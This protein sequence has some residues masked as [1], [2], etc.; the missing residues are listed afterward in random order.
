MLL[1]AV[2]LNEYHFMNHCTPLEQSVKGESEVA[3]LQA[4]RI[5]ARVT[6]AFARAARSSPD[7]HIE[8]FQPFG[9]AP[10]RGVYAAS[11]FASAIDQPFR[12]GRTHV[13]A[14]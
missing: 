6:R 14:A 9:I 8:G 4:S 11:S 7:Y 12:P 1:E 2:I 13:E 3:A 5:L 10:E